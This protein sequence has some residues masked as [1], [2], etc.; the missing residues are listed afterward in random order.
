MPVISFAQLLT[1]T[2]HNLHNALPRLGPRTTSIARTSPHFGLTRLNNP[3]PATMLIS[4][5]SYVLVKQP[6]LSIVHSDCCSV[7]QSRV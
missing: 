4:L 3:P 2:Y 5:I 7:S 1:S 6:P